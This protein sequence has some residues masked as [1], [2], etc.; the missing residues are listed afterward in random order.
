MGTH[1]MRPLAA[2]LAF[3]NV[4]LGY[5]FPNPKQVVSSS[6]KKPNLWYFANEVLG[7][8]NEDRDLVYLTDGGHIE[9]LGMYELLRRR[10]RLIVAVD[11]EADPR[12]KFGSFVQLQRYARIDLGAKIELPWE[13]LAATSRDA[14]TGKAVPKKGP[15]CA[16]GT[17][18]YDNGGVG[19]LVYVKASVTGD[20]NDYIRDY[21][22]RNETFPH[23]TTGDQYFSEEQ[24]EVYR[25]LGFHAVNGMLN[26]L[27]KVQSDAGLEHLNDGAAKGTGVKEAAILMGIEQKTY[28]DSERVDNIS[29]VKLVPDAA[30]PIALQV[31]LQ[32]KQITELADA[33]RSGRPVK[34]GKRT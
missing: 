14:M 9:N 28:P 13:Q 30:Q 11:A 7:R 1:S 22:A 27:D 3:F 34:R 33:M 8:L 32:Q 18:E 6:K 21:N 17:I 5:W 16:I 15:H 25:A 20:E 26:G 2:L 31:N 10:C 23:E 12:M 4:R 19:V 29:L 24:F